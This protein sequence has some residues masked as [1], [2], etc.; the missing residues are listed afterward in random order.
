MATD[1]TIE[2]S[3]LALPHLVYHA[4][5]RNTITYGELGKSIGK[6]HRPIKDALGYIRDEIC[7]PRGLPMIN[8]IVV[9]KNSGL[10]GHS[11]LPEGTDDL[12]KQEYKDRFWR[13]RDEVFM[14]P[15]WDSL[16]IELGL[17]SIEKQPEDFHKEAHVYSDFISSHP[18]G[19]GENHLRLKNYIAENPHV[20][21]LP[22]SICSTIEFKFVSGDSCDVTFSLE[23]NEYIVVEIKNGER[24]ELVKGIYQAIK[25]RSLMKAEKGLGSD[26]TVNAFLVAYTIPSDIAQFASRFNIECKAITLD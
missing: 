3:R 5:L 16:L 12:S 9:N 26:V 8:A 17:E 10:P 18:A 14:F 23:N 24:G 13:L 11:F 20:I 1:Y 22:T 25:Y 7:V 21:G 4:H 19:E 15:N 2:L 6:H